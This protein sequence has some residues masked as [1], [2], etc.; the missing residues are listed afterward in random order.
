MTGPAGGL[1]P[2]LCS[3]TLRAQP[4]AAVVRL[5]ADAGLACVE[6]GGDVHV[7]PGE[8][9]TAEAVRASTERAGLAVSGY[10]SYFRATAPDA[11]EID[12][13]V[14]TA[15]RLGAPRIRIWAGTVG[16]ATATPADRAAVAEAA[17]RLVDRAAEHA[18]TVA[19][20]F[21]GGTLTDDP[22]STLRLLRAVDRPTVGSY[23]QPPNGRPDAEALA[24]L[25]TV[26]DQV[27][28]VHVFSWWPDSQRLPLA[29]R[30]PLWRAAFA[31]L[32][33]ARRP[34]DALLEFVPDDDPTLLAGEA[35]TLRDLLADAT[36]TPTP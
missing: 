5:A 29:A 4:P 3:V 14:A 28:A 12:R 24:G 10:G 11:A 18:I 22:A 8:P 21:H 1:R 36:P 35:A 31:T 26:L 32:R 33:Q 6:W 15:V 25:A 7:P 2:G 9:G 20:E 34:L 30:A 19:F 13:V 27:M 23:W 16:S 17:G